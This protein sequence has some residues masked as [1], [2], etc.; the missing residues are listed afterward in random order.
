MTQRSGVD[1]SSS[2]ETDL[3]FK[4]KEVIKRLQRMSV[5]DYAD[6]PGQGRTDHKDFSWSETTDE[7]IHRNCGSLEEAWVTDV[8]GDVLRPTGLRRRDQTPLHGIFCCFCAWQFEGLFL[9]E[10]FE[11]LAG[12]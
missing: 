9:E 1:G 8:G 10:V 6:L 3:P 7:R 5:D 12:V 4:V 2:T 11:G